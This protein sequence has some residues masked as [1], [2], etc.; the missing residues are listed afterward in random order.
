M[1]MSWR[2]ALS[3]GVLL[4]I[5]AAGAAAATAL[6][7]DHW[8]DW[9]AHKEPE[10]K[11]EPPHVHEGEVHFSDQALDNLKPQVKRVAPV[12][13]FPRYVQVT[14]KVIER[15]GQSD[16]GISAPASAVITAIH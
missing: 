11:P 6:T 10:K 9:F 13:S 14:G 1:D 2:K 16:F 12:R 7:H 8:L 3:L 5:V 4:A 15:P